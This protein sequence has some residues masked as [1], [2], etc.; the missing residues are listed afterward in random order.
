VIELGKRGPYV[1]L[2][3]AGLVNYARMKFSVEKGYTLVSELTG[4]P[5]YFLQE[6]AE[7][8]NLPEDSI[9][10]VEGE[11]PFTTPW[12][13]VMIADSAAS[14]YEQN[15]LLLNLNEPCT[16]K[17]ISFIRPGKVI[18]E[19]TLTTEGG[20]ACV[21]FAVRR[22]LQYVEFD[23]GWYGN[24]YDFASDASFVSIDPL[25]YRSSL[26]LQKVIAYAKEKGI[27]I[28]LYINHRAMVQQLDQLLPLY[29]KWGVDGLKFG[30]VETGTQRWTK[31][32]HECVR[33]AAQYG[34][35]LTVHDEYRPTGFQRTCPNL[36]TQEGIRGDEEKQPAENTLIITFTR[37][38]AGP[39]DNTICYFDQRVK[40]YW[41]HAYQLAKSVV[42][43]SPLQFLYWYDR[44]IGSFNTNGPEI[45]MA[46]LQGRYDDLANIIT[47]EPELEFFDHLVTTWD[48]TRVLAGEIGQ[49]IIMARRSGEH[50]FVGLMNARA[51]RS[52]SISLSFLTPEIEYT[53]DI[54]TD[55]ETL[56]T[57]T[58]VKIERI[59]VT[60]DKVLE[61]DVGSDKGLA[62]R[63]VPKKPS[64][65]DWDVRPDT[66]CNAGQ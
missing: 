17:D 34:F 39:A 23:A 41:S 38:L 25:R 56:N 1:A 21:D 27:R 26:D 52:F 40:E 57:R 32:L 65:E 14:L 4:K 33:K 47:D 53:A 51:A 13:V 2:A 66:M 31:W 55:D 16:L 42:L 35:V 50:W 9:I 54:Y 43:F 62:M 46:L 45:E 36:L 19:M 20:M 6:E 30:F 8:K 28:M 49:Y 48:E 59:S 15:D 5:L 63:I 37:M 10:K 22:N 61:Y 18:R 12:R 58:N 60:R 7:L 24:E 3:E 11:T 44:P 29:K 64:A